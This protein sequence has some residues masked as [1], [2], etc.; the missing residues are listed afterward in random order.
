MTD[1]SA[2]GRYRPRAGAPTRSRDGPGD[3]G[4]DDVP[5]DIAAPPA[6]EPDGLPLLGNTHQYLRDPLTFHERHARDLGDLVRVRLAGGSFHYVTHPDDIQR[7]LVEDQVDYRKASQVADAGSGFLTDG[8]F[9][10]TGDQWRRARTI[11]QPAFYRERVERYGRHAVDATREAT[12]DWTD[13]DRVDLG[14]VTKRITLDVLVR[15]LFDRGLDDEFG[16]TVAEAARTVNDFLDATSLRTILPLPEWVPTPA[17]RRFDA[18]RADFD[19]A[20]DDLLD[21]RDAA[22]R[23]DGAAGA[24]GQSGDAPAFDDIDDPDLLD[25][26]LAANRAADEGDRLSRAELRDNLVT[27]L[28]AGHETTALALTYAGHLLAGAPGAGDRLAM[29]VDTLDGDPTVADLPD[30]PYT[31]AVVKESMRRYPPLYTLF[32]EPLEPVTLG[33]YHVPAGATLVLPQR[34]VHDDPRWWD[35]PG[36]FRPERWLEGDAAAAA[37]ADGRDGVGTATDDRPEYAYFP[38]GG[39]PRHCIGARFAML[40]ARLALATLAREW[41]FTDPGEVRPSLNVTLQPTDPVAVTV[42]RR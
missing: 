2:P 1:R 18:A 26:L 7:V 32:R 6:P 10:A 3:G 29:E 20:V 21:D 30:L 5:A 19:T 35:D 17:K 15:A 37:V 39:G 22:L 42:R 8:M 13:G 12:A 41:R 23:E 27:F 9:L 40:E 4:R 24:E 28:F 25:L 33:G 14:T 31:E 11:A 34:I 38:F 16:R 36:T